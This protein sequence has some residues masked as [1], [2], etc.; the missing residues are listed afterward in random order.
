MDKL[1]PGQS[2]GAK[3][4]AT[5]DEKEKVYGDKRFEAVDELLTWCASENWRNLETEK[6]PWEQKKIQKDF[7]PDKKWFDEICIK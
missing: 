7:L 3:Y 6:A 5:A 2:P 4:K 1:L